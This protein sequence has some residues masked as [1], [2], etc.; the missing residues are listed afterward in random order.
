MQGVDDVEHARP[1]V[2]Q[3]PPE[4]RGQVPH[5]RRAEE[6][7]LFRVR[8][9]VAESAEDARHVLDDESVLL[10]VLRRGEQPLGCGPVALRVAVPRRRPGE[11][12]G[13]QPAAVRSEQQLGRRAD[14]RRGRSL[15]RRIEVG[16]RRREREAVGID[17]AEPPQQ[18]LDVE[19]ALGVHE[20]RAGQHH[21]AKAARADAV[22]R[23]GHRRGVLVRLGV[24]SQLDV[25]ERRERHRATGPS[26]PVGVERRESLGHHVDLPRLALGATDDRP[27]GD[28]QL[29]RPAVVERERTDGDR[30]GSIRRRPDLAEGGRRESAEADDP[31]RATRRSNAGGRPGRG[32]AHPA[33]LEEEPARPIVRQEVEGGPEPARR[34]DERRI[35]TRVA[36]ER[37]P[38]SSWA[39]P[40]PSVRRRTSS[41]PAA[42][43]IAT[44][45][46]GGGRYAIDLGR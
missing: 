2:V 38:V 13:L 32:D 42:D 4:R 37:V 39:A 29:G 43:S 3:T 36:H 35:Q 16:L 45:A 19:L 23:S 17:G 40:A 31:A 24:R 25:G 18:L 26:L 5:V 6:L 41:K 22:R 8:Q 10:A 7:R 44:S 28:Q 11:R 46:S 12:G 1:V 21:L 30:R 27:L 20:Q 33:P 9:V 34:G 15:D 14:E